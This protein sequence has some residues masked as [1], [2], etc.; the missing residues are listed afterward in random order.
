MLCPP[1]APEFVNVVSVSILGRV[2]DVEAFRDGAV[3]VFPDNSVEPLSFALIVRAAEVIA[4]PKKDL[5][6][7]ADNCN[8][9]RGVLHSVILTCR[10]HD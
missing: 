10:P 9:L 8:R 5:N 6:L 1:D 2:V 4:F 3:V 7:W